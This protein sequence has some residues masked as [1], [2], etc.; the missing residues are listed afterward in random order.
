M[1]YRLE[2]YATLE[3]CVKLQTIVDWKCSVGWDVTNAP[4]QNIVMRLRERENEDG[5]I[6]FPEQEYINWEQNRFNE[7]IEES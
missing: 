7:T 4:D 1:L 5:G 6:L 2:W 3:W